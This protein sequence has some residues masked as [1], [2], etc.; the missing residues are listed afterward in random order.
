MRDAL[1]NSN[2][3]LGVI[4]RVGAVNKVEGSVSKV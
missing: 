1:D 3:I 4:E 2:G